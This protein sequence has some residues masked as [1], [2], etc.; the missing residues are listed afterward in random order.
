M[1]RP[2]IAGVVNFRSSTMDLPPRDTP[3]QPATNTRQTPTPPNAKPRRSQRRA[4]NNQKTTSEQEDCRFGVRPPIPI[5]LPAPHGMLL[6]VATAAPRATVTHSSCIGPRATR[7]RTRLLPLPPR[8]AAT[9][10][11]ADDNSNSK[12]AASSHPRATTPAL[13]Q[14]WH[15]KEQYPG[16][17]LLFRVGD[18]Y[19][20]FFDDAVRASV[21]DTKR[22]PFSPVLAGHSGERQET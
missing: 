8:R 21:H 18:F 14:Y 11:H 10:N 1:L 22:V 15:F 3:P 13:R 20:T 6:A 2:R 12:P 17:L 7:A 19:E 16:Y 5:S 4:S 9:T